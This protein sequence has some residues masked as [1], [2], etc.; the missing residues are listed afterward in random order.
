MTTETLVARAARGIVDALIPDANVQQQAFAAETITGAVLTLCIDTVAA[1][2]ERDA[3]T[4][5]AYYANGLHFDQN[6]I[7]QEIAAEIRQQGDE[8]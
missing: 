6:G 5:E 2:R 7:S 3:Q 4:A 1:Q 8:R